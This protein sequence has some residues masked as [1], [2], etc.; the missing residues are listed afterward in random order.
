VSVQVPFLELDRLDLHSL[1][2]L[3]ILFVVQAVTENIA[4]RAQRALEAIG[5]RFLL[6]LLEG[7]C[8]AFAIFY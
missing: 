1:N 3:E 8:F 4:K 2:L 5:R 6:G 7:R